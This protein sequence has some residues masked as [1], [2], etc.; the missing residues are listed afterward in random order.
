MSKVY[1][2]SGNF[3]EEVKLPSVFKTKYRPD[4][5]RRAVLALQSTRR[6]SYGSDTLAGK[7]SSAHYHGKRAYRF[8]MMNKE[9]AR[10]PRIHG[11]GAGVYALRARVAPHTVKGRRAHPPKVEKVWVKK[12][13]QKENLF[14]IRSALGASA[15]LEIVNKRHKATEAPIIFL[16][17]FENVTKTKEAKSIIAKL[18][19]KELERSSQKKIKA[20]KAKMRNRRYHKKKGPL[21]IVSKDCS[22]LK[23]GR[24]IPGVEL[25]IA[26][27]LNAEMLAPGTQA[28]RLLILTKTALNM[29]GEIYD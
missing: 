10:M 26:N 22:L 19:P 7:K 1:D 15:N 29:V 12:I 13:N 14:A 2:L 5:I 25:C 21:I 23:A 20:G 18:L 9:L 3:V 17:T 24:N 8:S 28:G 16:D 27:A 4:V 6:Q 11:K